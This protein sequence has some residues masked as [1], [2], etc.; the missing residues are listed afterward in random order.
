MSE[1]GWELVASGWTWAGTAGPL[2][3]RPPVDL[4]GRLNAVTSTS[5]DGVGL[6]YSD[7][8]II[9][10]RYGYEQF[11]GRCRELGLTRIELELLTGWWRS[12]REQQ[13]QETAMFDAAS[14][15]DAALIKVSPRISETVTTE[16]PDRPFLDALRRVAD[17]AEDAS[18]SLALE[19]MAM[20]N[21]PDLQS[22]RAVL[23]AV[24]SPSLGLLLDTWHLGM[25]D[26]VPADIGQ[27]LSVSE[28][29]AVELAGAAK[30]TNTTLREASASC[31]ALPDR[32]DVDV[33]EFAAA[34]IEVGWA[35]P[36]GVEVM[37]PRSHDEPLA[38]FLHECQVA[39]QRVLERAWRPR[40]TKLK[41]I[42]GVEKK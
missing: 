30:K 1:S 13:E 2:D 29:Y 12:D 10:E 11:V 24:G 21:V 20:S 7:V 42:K 18:V 27:Y 3:A 9:R 39:A 37:S 34:L 26:A 28:I 35:G 15:L 17:Y 36:W 16:R 4:E 25:S 8:V 6:L 41:D 5:W 38:E 33:S 31:R 40:P 22:A 32:G 14:K 19:P 23:D